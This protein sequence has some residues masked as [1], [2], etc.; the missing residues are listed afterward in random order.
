MNFAFF[1]HSL[2][3]DWNHGN[4]HFVRGVCSD[5]VRRGHGVVAYEQKDNWSRWNLEHDHGEV[6]S[7]AYLSAYSE[8]SDVEHIYSLASVSGNWDD[9]SEADVVAAEEALDLP[10]LLRGVD[11]AVVHEWTPP[12]VVAAIGRYRRRDGGF[13]LLFHDTHH[14]IVSEP[15]EMEKFQLAHY[16]GV[17]AFGRV[18]TEAYEQRGWRGR[19]CTWHE[20]ADTERFKPL[21]GEKLGDLVWVGNWG[22]DERTAEL[23]EYLLGP[24]KDLRLNSVV[25]GVR[26]PDAAREALTDAGIA[27]GGYLPNFRAP[28]LFA[29]HKVTVHVPR[30]W[31][32]S[33]LPGIPT[34]RPF[35]ALA[36]A[37]PLISAPWRD[38]EG[39]FAPGE[40]FAVATSGSEMK[41]KLAFLLDHPD[42][43]AEQA[44]RGR[45]TV[46]ARHTCRHRVDELLEIVEG[47]PK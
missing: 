10:A 22:D 42:A 12:A 46:L 7:R 32:V 19:A 28:E 27:Y 40:D 18:L 45:A 38:A 8:L 3:S 25:Y 33:H 13:R 47:L 21:G 39:L 6:A 34:I 35:E 20:A 29:A 23:H 24:A 43:A 37:I 2:A 11:V 44:E 26:Y 36:C 9:P 5:L 31:Y 1:V 17:L 16:D 15:K 14:R 30:K 4:A 41:E